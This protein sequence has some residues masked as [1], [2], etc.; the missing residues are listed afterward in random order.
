M[1]DLKQTIAMT[2]LN[3]MLKKG[4]FDICT[5]QSVA[6]L[7]NVHP[8]VEEYRMLHALHCIDYNN[9]P[10]EIREALPELIR[11][12]LSIDTIYEFYSME[13]EKVY[14]SRSPFGKIIKMIGGGSH[15]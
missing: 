7:L 3:N 12:C 4:H 14:V 8:K 1:S 13:R 15:G 11:R 9:M 2:A 5:I 10:T 6:E